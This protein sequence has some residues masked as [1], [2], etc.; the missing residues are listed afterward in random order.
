MVPHSYGHPRG[1]HLAKRVEKL[2]TN[3]QGKV[4]QLVRKYTNGGASESDFRK[5]LKE[6]GVKTDATF[7]KLIAKHESG[8]FI[9]HNQ[10]GKEALRRVVEPSKYNH[11]NKINLKNPSYVVKD[12]QGSDPVGI[13]NELQ[14][15]VHEDTYV[16]TAN[17]RIMHSN[18]ANRDI[19]GSRVYLGVLGKSK[20]DVQHQLGSSEPNLTTW[21]K[22][23]T[24]K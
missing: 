23:I 2:K 15:K 21:D 18:T 1:R 16:P 8:D 12:L 17:L 22:G 11:A 19:F 7:N 4:E 9:T 3:T 6:Y 5:G 24:S 13:T 14:Q 10:F 20:I